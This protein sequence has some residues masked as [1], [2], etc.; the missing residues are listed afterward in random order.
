MYQKLL[1]SILFRRQFVKLEWHPDANNP[2]TTATATLNI[3]DGFYNLPGLQ[4]ELA[5]HRTAAE[6]EL[7]A[8]HQQCDESL[9]QLRELQEQETS[10]LQQ[11]LVQ[12]CCHQL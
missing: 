11:Q 8:E 5:K 1:S 6:E 2:S 9:Q 4:L 3:P 7:R 10:R 12:D